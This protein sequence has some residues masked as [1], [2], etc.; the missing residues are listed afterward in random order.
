MTT[1]R[2]VGAELATWFDDRATSIVPDGLLARSLA[3]VDR[4]RQR[5]RV[6]VATVATWRAP[7]FGRSVIRGSVMPAWVVLLLA[8]LLAAMLLVVGSQLLRQNL[9]VIA[10]PSTQPALETPATAETTSPSPNDTSAPARAA[11][12][13]M[14]ADLGGFFAA[15]DK[16][17]WVRTVDK[18]YRTEDTGRTWR[19]VQPAGWSATAMTTFVDE[20]TA[21]LSAGGQPVSILATHDGGSSW[22]AT[23]VDAGPDV[24]SPTFT[25][26]GPSS[27]F[28][29]FV[30]L[31]PSDAGQGTSVVVFATEDGGAT[32]SGP[33]RGLQP[34][35]RAS[36]N[37]LYPP[38]GGFLVD[39][40]GKGSFAFENWFYLSDDGGVNWTKYPFPA[41]ALAPK[42]DLKSVDDI[43]REA[44]GRLLISVR[45]EGDRNPIAQ[46][47][48]ESGDNASTWRLVYEEPPGD[49]DV[50]FLSDDTWVLTSGSPNEVRVTTDGGAHWSSLTPRLP[51]FYGLPQDSRQFATPQTGWAT[52]PCEFIPGR[53]CGQNR[54][55][56]SLF[57]TTDGGS[58]WTEVGQ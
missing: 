30:D 50:Q 28:A 22:I 35:F 5:P 31:K 26:H 45:D 57:V 40:A 4:T 53:D 13:A 7:R 23:R 1:D 44:N 58:T 25:F 56:S 38:T 17:A 52:L 24:S 34:H 43:R 46:A 19:E 27:G 32:W 47:I 15:S 21:Y 39:S 6:L 3:R 54:N 20:Q 14:F 2:N 8:G 37:K 33:E 16:V 29:T 9:L 10:D 48:Y 55:A 18:I 11:D 49:F 12:Q 51:M 42:N 36:G 41:G